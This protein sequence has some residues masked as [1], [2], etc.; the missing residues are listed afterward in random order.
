MNRKPTKSIAG[1]LLGAAMLTTTVGPASAQSR[2]H[3]AEARA[4]APCTPRPGRAALPSS[5]STRSSTA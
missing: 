2:A 5:A 3:R 4:S 1:A